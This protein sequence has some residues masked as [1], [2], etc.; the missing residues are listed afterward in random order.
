VVSAAGATAG[1]KELLTR[2][3]EPRLAVPANHYT[4][5]LLAEKPEQR[6]STPGF[7]DDAEY[8]YYSHLAKGAIPPAV[9]FKLVYDAYTE[10]MLFRYWWD[11]GSVWGE[12]PPGLN[13]F[14]LSGQFGKG[15]KFESYQADRPVPLG[16]RFG[17]QN[18][19]VS[20]WA[21]QMLDETP[22]LWDDAV[23]RLSHEDD[24][25][26]EFRPTVS[27]AGK[28]EPGMCDPFDLGGVKL[29]LVSTRFGIVV[30][31]TFK[32]SNSTWRSTGH[33]MVR[34]RRRW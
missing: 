14:D 30:Y 28:P 2:V 26:V 22:G 17:P 34:A 8:A 33:R 19:V 5:F 7:M 23:K 25:R 10:P 29:R 1:D 4:R 15:G 6:H 12:V 11:A 9:R 16:S 31:G 18:M 3:G 20:A 24:I 32:G 27:F 13:R 21:L